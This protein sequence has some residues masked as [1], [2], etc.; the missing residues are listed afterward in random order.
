[1]SH[2]YDPDDCDSVVVVIVIV[3]D[4][5]GFPTEKWPGQRDEMVPGLPPRFAAGVEGE[6]AGVC[7]PA[8]ADGAGVDACAV[9]SA[10]GERQGVCDA[11]WDQDC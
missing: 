7:R 8:S 4:E 9:V 6:S 3:A 5:R 2:W 10:V 1:M 11:G